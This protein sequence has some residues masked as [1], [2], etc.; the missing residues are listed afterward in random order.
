MVNNY[1]FCYIEFIVHDFSFQSDNSIIH[2]NIH[3][4]LFFKLGCGTNKN[5][6]MGNN[7]PCDREMLFIFTVPRSDNKFLVFKIEKKLK[8]I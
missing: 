1:F 7:S 3:L 6:K 8:K 5:I 4:G 2:T